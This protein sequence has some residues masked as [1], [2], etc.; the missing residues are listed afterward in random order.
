MVVQESM[1]SSNKP[2][3]QHGI[4]QHQ[5]IGNYNKKKL[6]WNIYK[7]NGFIPKSVV[8]YRPFNLEAVDFVHY[9]RDVIVHSFPMDDL[10]TSMQLGFKTFFAGAFVYFF[11]NYIFYLRIRLSNEK[12]KEKETENKN[13]KD[14]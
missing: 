3:C 12:Y 7:R 2:L 13:K 6:S 5:T 8:Y 10:I 4:K 1:H 11:L 14:T 9:K